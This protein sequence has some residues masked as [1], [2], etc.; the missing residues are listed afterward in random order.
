MRTIVIVNNPDANLPLSVEIEYY[1]SAG[2]LVGT[3]TPLPI[4]PEGHYEEP[5]A[6]LAGSP[7]GTVR[8]LKVSATDP[9]FVG[10]TMFHTYQIGLP[11]GVV[12]TNFDLNRDGGVGLDDVSLALALVG[13]GADHTDPACGDACLADTN[14]D[15]GVGMDDVHAILGAMSG[16]SAGGAGSGGGEPGKNVF[17][18][19][20]HE[21]RIG[22]ASMQQLQAAQDFATELF[23]GPLPLTKEATPIPGTASPL[24]WDFFNGNSPLIM[25]TNPNPYAV[26]ATILIVDTNGA[27]ISTMV[28]LAP[29]QSYVDMTFFDDVIAAHGSNAVFDLDALV[30]VSA[31]DPADGLLSPVVGQGVMFDFFSGSPTP[32]NPSN[33]EFMGRFRMG[34]SM[35]QNTLAKTLVSPEL[36]SEQSMIATNTLLGVANASLGDIGP[37]L[38]E[39]RNRS[40]AVVGS[41]SIPNV[42][43]LWTLRLGPESPGYPLAEFA[44]SVTVSS[45]EPGLIGWNMKTT[46]YPGAPDNALASGGNGFELRKAWG[47]A[48]DGGN[49][50][51]PGGDISNAVFLPQEKVGPLN[52]ASADQLLGAAPGYNHV[53]N[54]DVS[55]TGGYWYRF[56]DGFGFDWSTLT[57]FNGITI[58][59]TSFTYID[60]LPP[61]V[62]DVPSPIPGIINS[63]F[64]NTRFEHV[65]RGGSGINA[66]GGYL[67]QWGWYIPEPVGPSGYSG[68]GDIIPNL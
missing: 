66:L 47:E 1:N 11:G 4:P 56:F 68:P 44:G 42:P 27:V 35:F 31:Q 60:G 59:S 7:W 28:P 54:N 13:S 8:V 52:R 64:I 2:V 39:Y 3:S 32:Q 14:Q 43:A 55:N 18:S 10:A 26:E 17:H 46:E 41:Q 61:L 30:W 29:F 20:T 62:Q 50:P 24:S 36:V 6:L 5:A 57:F 58:G 67:W 53:F 49:G 45:C 33:Q 65:E 25:V 12:G 34:S 38:V 19:E 9:D 40:G 16:A 15:G 23:W 37:V 48:L 21:H 51:E 63:D 22:A